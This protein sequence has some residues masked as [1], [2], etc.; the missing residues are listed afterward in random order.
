[1]IKEGHR[2]RLRDGTITPPLTRIRNQGPWVWL[3]VINGNV[4]R[5]DKWGFWS[6]LTRRHELD[7]IE[8]L[9][10]SADKN[11]RQAAAA[12]VADVRERHPGED[13]YCERL[14]AVEAALLEDRT[15]TLDVFYNPG[16]G[17]EAVAGS[18]WTPSH[19]ISFN[20]HEGKPDLSSIRM[21]EINR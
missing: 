2:A 18:T 12:L 17:V 10:A 5:W 8:T 3:A 20:T 11:L 9:P 6:K 21:E 7:I 19:R 4:N 15:E 1:M 14:K 16:F 13:L